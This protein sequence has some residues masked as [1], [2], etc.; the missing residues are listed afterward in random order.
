MRPW[1][2]YM[3]PKPLRGQHTPCDGERH[4]CTAAYCTVY[5]LDGRAVSSQSVLGETRLA[6]AFPVMA[7]LPSMRTYSTTVYVLTE[8]TPAERLPASSSSS[9]VVIQQG[10][11]R[12]PTAD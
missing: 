11:N 10:K 1:Q 12:M 2:A 4:A 8:S 7:H 9:R 6:V 3:P 5:S